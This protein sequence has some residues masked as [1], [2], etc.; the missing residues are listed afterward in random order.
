[1]TAYDPEAGIATPVPES[2]HSVQTRQRHVVH[3]QRTSARP[4][5]WRDSSAHG[6]AC[7]RLRFPLWPP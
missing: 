1:M 5:V 6:R 4:A 3:P 2:S 7:H